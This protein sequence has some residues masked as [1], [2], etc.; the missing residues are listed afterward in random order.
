MSSYS[1]YLSLFA[2]LA[3]LAGVSALP[4]IW[5]LTD[6]EDKGIGGGFDVVDDLR[7]P[8]WIFKYTYNQQKTISVNNKPYLIPDGISGSSIHRAIAFNETQLTNSWSDYYS[9]AFKSF[10]IS[11]AASYANV[12]LNAAFSSTK[13]YIKQLTK[14][15]TN[16]F[17]FN[18]AVYLTFALQFR[19]LQRPALDDDFVYDLSQLPATYNDAA[20]KRFLRAWGTHYFTRAVYGCQFNV[21]ASVDKKFQEQRSTQWATRQLDLTIKYNEIELGIKTEKVVNKTDIDGSFFDAA[22]VHAN[23]RGG[24]ETLFLV[25]GNFNGWLA[26]CGTMKVP[27]VMYSEVEPITEVV[28]NPTT[29]ANLHRAILAYGQ[30]K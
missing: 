13:G 23:A 18:G 24:D 9:Y 12:T 14:N 27:I 8:P 15:G 16:G 29:R 6:G 21:T 25:G 2:L 20:Y 28:T 17:G 19:G 10:S 22:Q 7:Q 1:T 3:V 5:D 30:G 11:L 4:P 26:S